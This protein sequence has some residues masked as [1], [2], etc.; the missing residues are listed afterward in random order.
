MTWQWVAILP[1]CGA[2]DGG[3]PSCWSG[4]F[5]FANCCGDPAAGRPADSSCW[6]GYFTEELCCHGSADLH[7]L[8]SSS[9]WE[10]MGLDARSGFT[11]CCSPGTARRSQ[12]CWGTNPMLTEARCCGDDLV[13]EDPANLPHDA[14]RRFD[15]A[16]SALNIHNYLH[17]HQVRSNPGLGKI[18][19]LSDVLTVHR[20]KLL[21]VI[22]PKD[23]PRASAKYRPLRPQALQPAS[24]RGK[25]L[26]DL[27]NLSQDDLPSDA[28]ELK[29]CQGDC[30]NGTFFLLYAESDEFLLEA[31][32]AV[33]H[34]GQIWEAWN[35]GNLRPH[36]AARFHEKYKTR[37]IW[38]DKA[39]LDAYV[40][41]SAT[42]FGP[43]RRMAESECICQALAMT[44]KLPGAYMEIGV[45]EGDAS[46]VAMAYMARSRLT[47][48]AYFLDTFQGF[49]YAEAK[50]S[51][52]VGFAGTHRVWPTPELAVDAIRA[53]LLQVADSPFELVIANILRDELPSAEREVAVAYLDV[54]S[55]EA[56]LAGLIK[57][58]EKLVVGGII[59]MDDAP[60]T[61]KLA[62][63]L[64][65]MHEFMDQYQDQFV[66]MLWTG[67]YALFRIK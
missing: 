61:P 31:V 35:L 66:K 49:N 16:I 36:P 30:K 12:Q 17:S 24:H 1:L 21:E 59:L 33:Q 48:K 34:S 40:T 2:L 56:T 5:T 18:F 13:D 32:S 52:E 23:V 22:Q 14:V 53:K 57:L 42:A 11:N 37:Y 65:A 45:F 9:C 58:Q 29:D 44:K 64:L 50:Q 20:P 10:L 51:T 41:A 55:Y 7:G 4:D 60:A 47:R 39:C 3:N 28:E 6:D 62:G 67:A 15:T 26:V 8:G 19:L 63:A 54:D 38:T 46:L 27:P 43:M 25:D